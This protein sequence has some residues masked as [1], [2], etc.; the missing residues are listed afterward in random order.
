MSPKKSQVRHVPQRTCIVCGTTSAKRAL[1][2]LVR[3]SSE[4]VQVDPT[5]K[6]AGRGAYL[7]DNPACW[8]TAIK[9]QALNK[10]LRTSVTQEDRARLHEA[11]P[12]IDGDTPM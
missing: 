9:G 5:G 3:T 7:C 12:R 1:T 11:A 2:R 4:G 6:K 8:E 10:A